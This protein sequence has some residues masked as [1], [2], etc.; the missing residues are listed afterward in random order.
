MLIGEHPHLIPIT[1]PCRHVHH[2]DLTVLL[3]SD[4]MRMFPAHLLH[5]LGFVEH[6]AHV[7]QETDSE[8]VWLSCSTVVSYNRHKLDGF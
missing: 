4:L 2:P 1:V 7:G 6:S 5:W 8:T 3:P